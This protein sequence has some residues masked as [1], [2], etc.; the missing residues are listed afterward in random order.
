MIIIRGKIVMASKILSKKNAK[1]I[2][3]KREAA[4]PKAQAVEDNAHTVAA[5]IST[6]PLSK[7]GQLKKEADQLD[8]MVREE[9]KQV[10]KGFQLGTLTL[11]VL[12]Q[13]TQIIIR[14][15][16]ANLTDPN[17]RSKNTFHSEL[18][19]VVKGN[20][21]RGVN[22]L[23][24]APTV[25]DLTKTDQRPKR[26]FSFLFDVMKTCM[27]LTNG[28]YRL[29]LN[30]RDAP[31]FDGRETPTP[32]YGLEIREDAMIDAELAYAIEEL[33]AWFGSICET[34]GYYDQQDRLAALADPEAP[35][36]KR[37]DRLFPVAY[38]VDGTNFVAITDIQRGW[39]LVQKRNE[40]ANTRRLENENKARMDTIKSAIAEMEG[41]DL[42]LR[43][44]AVVAE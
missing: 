9:V 43:K 41:Y 19:K 7:S 34:M 33:Q 12:D 6:K 14:R 39:D 29:W 10:K 44:A 23:M 3:A 32:P 1:A 37:G 15:N 24:Q 4:E 2:N 28:R 31:A 40:V 11:N 30:G 26:V 8:A 38:E 17:G 5:V 16:N 20:I 13:A 42:P 18:L 25:D 35:T 22:H 27:F 36:N 21:I